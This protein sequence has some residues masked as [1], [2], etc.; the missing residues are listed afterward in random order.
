MIPAWGPWAK[1]PVILEKNFFFIIIIVFARG[2]IGGGEEP[3]RSLDCRDW[4]K[5]SSSLT[6]H[7]S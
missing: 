5:L 7:L 2:E 3:E 6:I 4:S 1:S